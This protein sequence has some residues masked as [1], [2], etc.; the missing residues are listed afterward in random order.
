MPF[1][2]KTVLA[3]FLV[4]FV[5]IPSGAA[6]AG[7]AFQDPEG[8][9][10]LDLPDGWK[11]L[12][13]TD[14]T[15]FSFEGPEKVQI[16]LQYVP[17][18]KDREE[19]FGKSV[20]LMR[21]GGVP[22][23]APE[24]E[25]S[26]MEVSGHPAR[27]GVYSGYVTGTKIRLYGL[28]GGVALKDGGA[29]FAVFLNAGNRKPMGEK[30]EKVFTSLR[31]PGEKAT[32]VSGRMAVAAAAEEKPAPFVHDLVTME[33]PPGWKEQPK[34]RSF[35]KE[36]VGFFSSDRLSGAT[37]LIACYE[38]FF[39]NMPKAIDASRK[40]VLASIPNAGPVAVTKDLKTAAGR[41][42]V[43]ITYEGT[44]PHQGQDVR[45]RVLTATAKG[46]KSYVNLL[47]FVVPNLGPAASE[48]ILRMANSIR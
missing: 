2:S 32:G 23:A 22:D 12:P 25:L 27:L 17:D 47:L 35:E 6:S 36:V 19:L 39:M 48:Q 16:V 45:M 3:L 20:D 38:G 10:E 43:L 46:G 14:T 34:A 33:L 21:G 11:L 44:Q 5:V 4:I 8:R 18:V 13:Q 26:D 15:V 9:F 29:V 1:T 31:L 37:L 42:L 28:L 41:E 40:T 30:V 24:G 7:N